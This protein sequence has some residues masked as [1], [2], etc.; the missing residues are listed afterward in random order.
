VPAVPMNGTALFC[1]PQTLRLGIEPAVPLMTELIRSDPPSA[2][3]GNSPEIRGQI[4]RLTGHPAVDRV[5][6][7][8][9]GAERRVDLDRGASDEASDLLSRNSAW[10][11]SEEVV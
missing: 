2:G 5:A 4:A 10:V 9:I 11:R 6:D 7:R 8:Q 3:V 1:E